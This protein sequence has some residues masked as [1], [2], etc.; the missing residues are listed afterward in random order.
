MKRAFALHLKRYFWAYLLAGVFSVSIWTW[1]IPAKTKPKAKERVGVFVAAKVVDQEKM[2]ARI[3]AQGDDTLLEAEIYVQDPD[4]LYF[5][6]S[7][8]SS[9]RRSSD[10]YLLPSDIGD[11]W[12]RSLCPG[13]SDIAWEETF[14]ELGEPYHIGEQ[15]YGRKV[16]LRDYLSEETDQEKDY[17]LFL[18]RYSKNFGSFYVPPE[19]SA[20][21]SHGIEAIHALFGGKS[22]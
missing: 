1:V 22:S 20:E 6:P 5:G 3:L 18:N 19:K 21:S 8:Q 16:E 14:P 4:S 7:I 15:C 9:G 17:Y 2:K 12:I 10:F 13:F 11:D